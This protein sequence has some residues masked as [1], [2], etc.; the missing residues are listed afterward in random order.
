MSLNNT[1]FLPDYQDNKIIDLQITETGAE[2]LSVQEAKDHLH[3]TYTDDDTDLNRM[4]KS[5]RQS[6]EKFCGI[7]LVTKTV[8]LIADLFRETELP[9]G[10]VVSF[11]SAELKTDISTYTLQTADDSYTIES[12]AFARIIPYAGG[13]WRL[14][15]TVGMTPVDQD[16]ILAIRNE[17]AFRYENRGEGVQQRTGSK[18]G[19]CEAAQYLATPFKRMAWV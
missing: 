1:S 17:L 9:Q 2:P 4:I 16:L 12:G 10:P 15:Y 11:T 13:R 7:S 8:V 14:S 18:P 6:I 5:C 19:I 3:I